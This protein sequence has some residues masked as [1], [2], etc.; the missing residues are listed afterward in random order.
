MMSLEAKS[1]DF[2]LFGEMNHKN[3][4]DLLTIYYHLTTHGRTYK[5]LVAMWN[6]TLNSYLLGLDR[7]VVI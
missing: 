5:E 3:R 4:V 7:P 2:S 1:A 6:I